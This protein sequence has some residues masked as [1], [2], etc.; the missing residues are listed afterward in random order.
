MTKFRVGHLTPECAETHRALC[1][2]GVRSFFLGTNINH[3]SNAYAVL[4]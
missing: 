2:N 1:P 4:T 3:N